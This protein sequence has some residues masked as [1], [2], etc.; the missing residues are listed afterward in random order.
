MLM[1]NFFVYYLNFQIKKAIVIDRFPHNLEH[2]FFKAGWILS[3]ALLEPCVHM[4][5]GLLTNSNKL[6]LTQRIVNIYISNNNVWLFWQ[7]NKRSC[8]VANS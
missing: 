4:P 8:Q 7:F 6:H 5:Q 3:L 1:Y 2:L